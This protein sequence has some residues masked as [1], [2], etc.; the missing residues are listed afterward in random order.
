[1]DLLR[2]LTPGEFWSGVILLGT[3]TGISAA[4]AI[5]IGKGRHF[6]MGILLLIM[7]GLA[8]STALG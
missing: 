8:L 1:M 5:A 6:M 7:I 4:C 3:V 2:G